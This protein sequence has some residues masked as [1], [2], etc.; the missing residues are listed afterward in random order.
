M[1]PMTCNIGTATSPN[2]LDLEVHGPLLEAM[3]KN[4]GKK[5]PPENA[6]LEGLCALDSFYRGRLSKTKTK[7]NT[8]GLGRKGPW[9]R[10]TVRCLALPH[11]ASHIRIRPMMPQRQTIGVSSCRDLN[12]RCRPQPHTPNWEP[13]GRPQPPPPDC[14]LSGLASLSKPGPAAALLV[15]FGKTARSRSDPWHT[16]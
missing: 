8:N 10:A 9:I 4:F 12:H 11:P 14:L 3:L 1:I 13:L 16:Y 15:T 5:A 7:K 2:P 6:I